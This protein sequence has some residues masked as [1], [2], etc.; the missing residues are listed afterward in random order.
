MKSLLSS[1]HVSV[2]VLTALST[3]VLWVS[4]ML[5]SQTIPPYEFKGLTAPLIFIWAIIGLSVGVIGRRTGNTVRRVF[6][7]A[8]FSTGLSPFLIIPLMIIV[9]LP[10]GKLAAWLGLIDPATMSSEVATILGKTAMVI[11]WI[12]VGLTIGIT[13]LF[14]TIKKL[15]PQQD[16]THSKPG[17]LHPFSPKKEAT[18]SRKLRVLSLTAVAVLIV[19]SIL[20]VVNWLSA[21][22]Q[23]LLIAVP[24]QQIEQ[25]AVE[26]IQG[27]VPASTITQIHSRRTTLG[28]LIGQPL[29]SA[30]QVWLGEILVVMTIDTY[31]PCDPQ[32]AVWVVDLDGVFNFPQGSTN[33]AQVVFDATG[34]FIRADSP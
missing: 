25:R 8:L 28:Q 1:K 14:V 31:N 34:Y 2:G 16:S 13:L 6:F 3:G 19:S 18:M 29:C 30:P 11:I 9:V 4:T 24:Q 20:L 27:W 12:V 10:L 33:H 26:Q 32:T 7:S 23:T 21:R 22:R 5:Y 15:E 17:E